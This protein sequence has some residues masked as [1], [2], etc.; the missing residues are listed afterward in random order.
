ML[1]EMLDLSGNTGQM[2]SAFCHIIEWDHMQLVHILQIDVFC[3]ECNL[4]FL[5]YVLYLTFF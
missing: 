5:Q 3:Q 2:P 1:Y 4:D